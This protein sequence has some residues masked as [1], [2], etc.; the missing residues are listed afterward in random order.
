MYINKYKNDKVRSN[1]R[2]KNF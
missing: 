1:F 2:R